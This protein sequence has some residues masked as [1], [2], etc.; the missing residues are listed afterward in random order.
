MG[1]AYI[2]LDLETTGLSKNIHKITEIAAIKVKNNEII[3]KFHTLVNPQTK[4]PKFITRLTGIDN[5]LVKDAPTID[6]VMPKFLNFMEDHTIVAHNASFDHGFLCHNAKHHLNHELT[7]N[8]LCTR[9]LANRLVPELKS[10]R[11]SNLCEHFNLTND[12]AHRAMSD[13]K[14]TYQLFNEFLN[15][16]KEKG[17][18]KHED[19][20][21]FQ[22][23]RISKPF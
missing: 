16:M 4:I 17:I 23:S 19:I 9:R 7:N 8:K 22:S 20:L 15:I 6:K 5:E 10:K 1:D 2:I 18:E 11:L 13:A 14:V 21:K 12:N 3:D